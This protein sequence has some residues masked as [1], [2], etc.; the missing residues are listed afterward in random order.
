MK[1]WTKLYFL[2][3]NFLAKKLN[4]SEELKKLPQKYTLKSLF[5]KLQEMNRCVNSCTPCT[6]EILKQSQVLIMFLLPYF[7]R[8]LATVTFSKSQGKTWT[9]QNKTQG[10]ISPS[11]K[12]KYSTLRTLR[13]RSV[14]KVDT[15]T[16]WGK[17]NKIRSLYQRKVNVP[18]KLFLAQL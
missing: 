11:I 7:L 4:L 12:E 15:A 2:L 3:I 8:Y 5:H 14:G 18:R 17:T 10:L 16:M 1:L 13:N 6:L 9:C